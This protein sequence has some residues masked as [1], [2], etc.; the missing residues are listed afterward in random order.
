MLAG[1]AITEGIGG[2]ANVAEAY[3][4]KG[5]AGS[6]TAAQTIGQYSLMGG[7]IGM[8]SGNPAIAGIGALGGAVVGIIKAN[9]DYFSSRKN[10][11]VARRRAEIQQYENKV[12]AD[13]AIQEVY[14]QQEAL[15]AAST[16]TRY[17]A[18]FASV[19]HGRK[20]NRLKKILSNQ[21]YAAGEA[22]KYQQELHKQQ[23]LKQAADERLSQLYGQE[24]QRVEQENL[25]IQRE[26]EVRRAKIEQ[27]RIE[28]ET[29]NYGRKAAE[30][31]LGG[32]ARLSEMESNAR[33]LAG[34]V[35]YSDLKKGYGK[36]G[37]ERKRFLSLRIKALNDARN[38]N[39]I[40]AQGGLLEQ[41]DEYQTQAGFM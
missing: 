15:D 34:D 3:G 27:L 36:Y 18:R 22:Q 35:S 12:A 14:R 31:S 9:T 2:L 1:Y 23:D 4:H 5:L 11:Q 8:M 7:S 21:D 41:A 33:Y 25:R 26:E 19:Y 24:S 16:M 17:E 6:L 20:I 28:T 40:E 38:A 29:L 37:S 39:S 10:E 32:L 13:R 30:G